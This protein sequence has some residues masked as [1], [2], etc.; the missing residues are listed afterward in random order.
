[1]FASIAIFLG[2][3]W[4]QWFPGTTESTGANGPPALAKEPGPPSAEKPTVAPSPAKIGSGEPDPTV[5]DG[6]VPEK[7]KP[8]EATG[9]ASPTPAQLP[10]VV[11]PIQPAAV[12]EKLA[13]AFLTEDAHAVQSALGTRVVSGATRERLAGLFESHRLDASNAVSQLG[14]Q[15]ALQ[16]WAL[17]LK[18]ES[19]TG[20]DSSEPLAVEVEFVRDT[21]GQW[22][23][24]ALALP[25]ENKPA[26]PVVPSADPEALAAA[27]SVA[28][29]LAGGALAEL[30][31]HLDLQRFSP[32]QATGLAIMLQEGGFET[33]AGADPVVTLAGP[34]QVWLMMPVVSSSWQTESQFGLILRRKAA[35]DPWYVAAFNPDSLL[36]VTANRLG[37]GDAA[38]SLV[39]TPG[40]PDA[41]CLYFPPNSADADERSRRVLALTAA[42]L[43]AEPTLRAR[44]VGHADA[45]ETGGNT[46]ALPRARVETAVGILTAAGIPGDILERETHGA[47]RPRRANF[48]P[49]G[50]ADPRALLLNRRVEIFFQR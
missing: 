16:R 7:E 34:T 2:Y 15:P 32:A 9:S 24:G 45:T 38:T 31:P 12:M 50:S 43:N 14:S 48:L 36:A 39:R 18:A 41:L 22:W 26:P 17:Y 40:Q 44:L 21:R 28:A 37:A 33:K 8:M 46:D 10:E 3:A 11:G 42:M 49:D 5:A 4:P 35:G 30:V 23:P 6:I 47:R 29:A 19:A 13:T 27:R 20:P 25:E 1:M